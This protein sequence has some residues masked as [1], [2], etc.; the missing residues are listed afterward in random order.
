VLEL[1]D[2]HVEQMGI[3]LGH[4]LKIIKRIK[5]LRTEQGLSVPQSAQ[6]TRSKAES[7]KYE[8]GIS[9]RPVTQIDYEEL[10]EP[11]AEASTAVMTEQKSAKKEKFKEVTRKVT[12]K[13]QVDSQVGIEQLKDG[14]YNEE[15]SHAGFMDAL[16]A[17]R[18][19]GKPEE[20]KK[21]DD[22][23]I[24]MRDVEQSWKQQQDNSKKGSFF[25]NID[26][27]ESNFDFGLIPT[28]QEGG[29]EPDRKISSKE[30]CWQCFKLY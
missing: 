10:P 14:Q 19:A 13:D 5:D 3:P 6:S 26:K 2:K 29:T 11:T 1:Q 8:D 9:T 21:K 15:E 27:K 4:K 28:W 30:S 12:F 22:K 25:A 16:K 24:K 17:W 7:V 20:E 18:T 23:K